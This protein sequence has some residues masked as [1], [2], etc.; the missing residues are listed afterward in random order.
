MAYTPTPKAK[1]ELQALQLGMTPKAYQAAVSNPDAFAPLTGEQYQELVNNISALPSITQ[2]RANIA[3][4]AQM[5]GLMAS[6]ELQ[7]DLSPVASLIDTFSGGK[8]NLAKNY[9]KPLSE[10]E[11]QDLLTKINS[12]INKAYSE[13]SDS[14]VAILK[15][16]LG[17]RGVLGAAEIK[18]EATTEAAETAA[19]A[20]IEAAEIGAQGK[21]DAAN[22]KSEKAGET[23]WMRDY[24]KR[25][26]DFV[27]GGGSARAASTIA[28]FKDAISTLRSN[29]DLSG[30]VAASTPLQKFLRQD[31][32]SF[33]SRIKSATI[34]NLKDFLPPGPATDTDVKN[35]LE[36]VFDPNQNSKDAADQLDE[37]ADTLDKMYISAKE[38]AEYYQANGNSL[39]GYKGRIWEPKDFVIGKRNKAAVKGPPPKKPGKGASEA[40]M[41]AYLDA[42]KA[43]NAQ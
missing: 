11:R 43:Y 20:K 34:A 3:E 1:Q 29:Y 5:G 24:A 30:P 16:Q 7:R 42:L 17:L 4:Q 26:N 6:R 2:Q 9:A 25:F 8:T 41:K 22:T 12:G 13:L 15:A 23:A 36:A 27:P 10:E 40:E 38:A 37:I 35:A 33:L 31:T 18:G 39:K 19:G 32:Y 14:E 21:V 28:K